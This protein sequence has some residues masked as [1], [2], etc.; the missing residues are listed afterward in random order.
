MAEAVEDK[1]DA[2]DTKRIHTYPLIRVIYIL[3]FEI[4]SHSEMFMH[5][6]VMWVENSK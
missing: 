5:A 1:K 3:L 4:R 6:W 2:A